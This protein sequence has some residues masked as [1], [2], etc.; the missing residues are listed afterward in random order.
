MH[1]QPLA[2][3]V[4]GAQIALLML[5]W[6]TSSGLV[7]ALILALELFSVFVISCPYF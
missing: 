4:I 2:G 3:N 5:Y 6:S 7:S 1:N